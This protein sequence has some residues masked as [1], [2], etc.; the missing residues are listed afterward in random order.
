MVIPLFLEHY[1]VSHCVFDRYQTACP[2]SGVVDDLVIFT[3]YNLY[4]VNLKWSALVEKFRWQQKSSPLRKY[5]NIIILIYTNN[6]R[7]TSLKPRMNKFV[8]LANS[9]TLGESIT[10]KLYTQNNH[11]C[12]S[13]HLCSHHNHHDAGISKVLTVASLFSCAAAHS[14]KALYP[15]SSN[16]EHVSEFD[17]CHSR[18]KHLAV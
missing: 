14:L 11:F 7:Q 18:Y 10:E 6:I 1:Q 13:D 3:L 2:T 15:E 9:R 8:F 17:S 12:N 16:W 5:I 4:T